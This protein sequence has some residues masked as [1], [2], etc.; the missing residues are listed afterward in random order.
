MSLANHRAW[1]ASGGNICCS[2]FD[3]TSAPVE[4]VRSHCPVLIATPHRDGPGGRASARSRPRARLLVVRRALAGVYSK[5]RP[6]S[7]PGAPDRAETDRAGASSRRWP[8]S[9]AR[10]SNI[11]VADRARLGSSRQSWCRVTLD[12]HPRQ[13]RRPRPRRAAFGYGTPAE[14]VPARRRSGLDA[15]HQGL[16]PFDCVDRFRAELRLGLVD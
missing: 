7:A 3:G 9:R 5:A 14:L 16:A 12:Q 6:R 11:V 13:S 1:R 10:T 2:A 8:H 15:I 4:H